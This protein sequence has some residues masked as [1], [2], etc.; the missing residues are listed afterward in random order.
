MT[1]LV[2]LREKILY[3]RQNMD[4]NSVFYCVY[5][6]EKIVFCPNDRK[7]YLKSCFAV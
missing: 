6:A 1:Y 5:E 3:T 2:V 4:K 7:I